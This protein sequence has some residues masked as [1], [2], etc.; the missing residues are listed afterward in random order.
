MISYLL[1]KVYASVDQTQVLRSVYYHFREQLP[2]MEQTTAGDIPK[3]PQDQFVKNVLLLK[4]GDFQRIGS[5][6]YMPTW[7]EI[8]TI[9]TSAQL[10]Q[11]KRKVEFFASMP[12][13]MVKKKLKE[14]FPYLKG[15]R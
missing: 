14:I 11:F 12:E 10:G 15:K 9:K 13:D 3:K 2:V 1:Q 7:G 8:S 6:V 4:N 5:Q